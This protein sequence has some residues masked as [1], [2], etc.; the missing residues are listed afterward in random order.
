MQWREWALNKGKEE[1]LPE[2]VEGVGLEQ[3]EGRRL[4]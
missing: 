4:T 3:G 1:G 2:A